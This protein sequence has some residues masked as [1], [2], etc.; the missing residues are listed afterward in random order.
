MGIERCVY[1]VSVSRAKVK[2]P[3]KEEDPGKDKRVVLNDLKKMG[4]KESY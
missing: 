1:T 4:C 3:I 2:Q